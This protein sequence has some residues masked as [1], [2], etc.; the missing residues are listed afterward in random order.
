MDF[1]YLLIFFI[2]SIRFQGSE[3]IHPEFLPFP[4]T[5]GIP[6][7]VDLYYLECYVLKIMSVRIKMSSYWTVLVGTVV[8][9]VVVK[10]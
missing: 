7:V 10:A 3:L 1:F 8:G 6:F 4:S 2:K 9:S 5:I